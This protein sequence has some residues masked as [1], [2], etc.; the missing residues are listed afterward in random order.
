MTRRL[1]EIHDT[2]SAS[3]LWHLADTPFAPMTFC[4][5]ACVACGTVN[6]GYGEP[7]NCRECATPLGETD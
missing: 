3:A 5:R 1:R 7:D 4:G 6:E 2:D